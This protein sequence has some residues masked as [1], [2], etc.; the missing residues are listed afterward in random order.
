MR[1]RRMRLLA[2]LVALSGGRHG[3]PVPL[4]EF[5]PTLAMDR[6]GLRSWFV[7]KESASPAESDSAYDLNTLDEEKLIDPFDTYYEGTNDEAKGAYVTLQ[8]LD[9]LVEYNKSWLRR[10]I[11]KQ[12]GNVLQVVVNVACLIVG[13]IVG[14]YLT[15]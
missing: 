10:A 2:R 13:W 3:I 4:S 12:P 11:D 6:S 15:P 7:A 5:A 8:G 14:R 9:A 1:K